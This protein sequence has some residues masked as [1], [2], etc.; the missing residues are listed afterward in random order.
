M[1][2]AEARR[3]ASNCRSPAWRSVMSAGRLAA[4]SRRR[5]RRGQR[6]RKTASVAVTD[7]ARYGL[8]SAACHEVDPFAVGLHEAERIGRSASVAAPGRPRP[9][10]RRSGSRCHR[11]ADRR[12]TFRRGDRSRIPPSSTF[13]RWSPASQ[14]GAA[15]PVTDSIRRQPVALVLLARLVR[16]VRDP[17]R[18]APSGPR[19]CA[20]VAARASVEHV[21]V[22]G[23]LTVA[24]AL[25]AVGAGVVSR[26]AVQLV[27]AAGRR[28][29]LIAQDEAGL[30]APRRTSSP[31]P[32]VRREPARVAGGC[33]RRSRRR[34]RHRPEA[35]IS[36]RWSRRWASAGR[37]GVAGSGRVDVDHPVPSAQPGH[38]LPDRGPPHRLT[39]HCESRTTS[40]RDGRRPTP[41]VV[42]VESTERSIWTLTSW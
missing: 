21:G 38:A 16:S 25:V 5:G 10:R 1:P 7:G 26:T 29:E 23:A 31:G 34:W 13:V 9:D 6:T 22:G 19:S 12:A 24:V 40:R 28:G 35:A 2:R 42:S 15:P 8:S 11:A 32:R 39:G 33:G 20:R 4:P 41:P 37:D 3:R 36:R 17:R 14:S 18:R 30:P 27:P